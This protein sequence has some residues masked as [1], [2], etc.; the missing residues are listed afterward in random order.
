MAATESTM[1][2]LGTPAPHFALPDLEGN[3]VCIDDLWQAKA[4][5][6]CFICP[7]CPYVRHVR[8]GVAELARDYAGRGLATVGI[9]SNDLDAYPQDGPEG[10]RQE[11]QE[12]GYSFPYLLDETQS[13][14]RAYQA[15]CTPDF[16]LFDEGRNLVYRGQL[17]SSRPGNDVPVTGEDL[18][19][20][21]DALL[22]GRSVPSEQRPSIG[23]NIKWKPGNSPYES[24]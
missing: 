8:R 1:L 21:I 24:A 15:A 23:C 22:E 19:G 12:A 11:A 14:A 7:H 3:L 2:G 10:M 9:M 18:R 16:F 6:V 5:L 20:A 17:D 13:V 4:L